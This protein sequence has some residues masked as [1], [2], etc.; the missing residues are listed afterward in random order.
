MTAHV[1]AMGWPNSAGSSLIH[2]LGKIADDRCAIAV[3]LLLTVL[4]L[5]KRNEICA[6]HSV[7]ANHCRMDPKNKI[8][9]SH[10]VQAHSRR[11]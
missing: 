1:R 10:A 2:A 11:K 5:D 8:E 4:G 3:T 6:P 7:A 9:M